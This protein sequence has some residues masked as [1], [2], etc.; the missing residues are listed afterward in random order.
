MKEESQRI[1]ILPRGQQ[2]AG[3]TA[4]G[5]ALLGGK[6]EKVISLDD[7]NYGQ[8]LS[9]DVVL[10]IELGY[11]ECEGM[12]DG[13]TRDPKPWQKVLA[14]EGRELFAFNL[15]VDPA[16]A[17][18]RASNEGHRSVS[19]GTLR[20]SEQ[21]QRKTEVVEFAKNAGITEHHID[22]TKRTIEEVANAIRDVVKT[23]RPHQQW[24]STGP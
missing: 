23:S 2:C 20:A 11:G 17:R 10:V 5:T 16:E 3:K 13:P 14:D 22:T 24:P 9:A 6:R 15:T 4:T 12:P 21:I 8:L 18:V 19:E 7:R 1:A